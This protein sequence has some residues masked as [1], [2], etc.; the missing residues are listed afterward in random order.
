MAMGLLLASLGILFAATIVGVLVVRLTP[1]GGRWGGLG[2][3]RAMYLSTTVLAGSAVTLE[4]AV[5]RLRG[6]RQRSAQRWL[7][8]TWWLGALFLLVQSASWW[9]LLSGLDAFGGAAGERAGAAWRDLPSG[10]PAGSGAAGT[11]GAAPSIAVSTLPAIWIF[12]VLTSLHA[13]HVVGG[14]VSMGIVVRHADAGRYTASA[15]AGLG[16]ARAYWHFLGVVWL[17]LLITLAIQL[18]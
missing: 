11:A 3:P 16:F 15:H 17:A 7:R 14:L 5:A 13:I 1:G 4:V 9:I 6:G 2:L 12:I 18:R 8:T 10:A